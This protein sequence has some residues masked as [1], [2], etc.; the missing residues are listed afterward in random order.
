MD[1]GHSPGPSF[2]SDA[3]HS[4]FEHPYVWGNMT[5]SD[6]STPYAGW[7][8]DLT[9]AAVIRSAAER[10]AQAGVTDPVVDA[11]LLVGHVLGRRRGELQAA[12]IRG[13]TMGE[14]DAA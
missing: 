8:P 14:Q 3:C 10:L 7:M 9:L 5:F 12:V 6:A 13:D 2:G 11:E 1:A 4:L